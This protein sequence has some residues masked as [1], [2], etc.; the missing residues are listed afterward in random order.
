MGDRQQAIPPFAVVDRHYT[1]KSTPTYP[2]LPQ[3]RDNIL[4]CFILF[5]KA[6]HPVLFLLSLRRRYGRRH[7]HTHK[8][9]RKGFTKSFDWSLS[10]SL[11]LHF[12]FLKRSMYLYNTCLFKKE[13]HI[14][15][16]RFFFFLY[17]SISERERGD[18]DIPNAEFQRCASQVDVTQW[19]AFFTP[20]APVHR[21]TGV[22]C[23]CCCCFKK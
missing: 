14:C 18:D 8:I 20:E 1:Q 3:H 4:L 12:S 5:S 13:K 15:L 21:T 17:N 23:C 11:S 16:T 7:T 10:F 22:F 19:A 6:S 9:I 2:P